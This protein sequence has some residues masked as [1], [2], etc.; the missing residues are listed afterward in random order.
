MKCPECKEEATLSGKI[1]VQNT[2]IKTK[3]Q[4]TSGIKYICLK[5]KKEWIVI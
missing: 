5:C 1:A 4:W 3:A 2:E